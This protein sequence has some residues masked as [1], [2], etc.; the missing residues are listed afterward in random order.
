MTT[1]IEDGYVQVGVDGAG[2]KIDNS[3]VDVGANTVYRERVNISD[4]AEPDNHARVQDF[5]N[6]LEQ[7][8]V[9]R[10]VNAKELIN[11]MEKL[12]EEIHLLR[13]TMELHTGI[14]GD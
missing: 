5:I 6:G 8:L 11:V 2:K 7:G 4:P 14:K 1:P 13:V 10:D 12:C 3:V 9:T